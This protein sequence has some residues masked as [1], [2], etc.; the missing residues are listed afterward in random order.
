[1]SNSVAVI[2]LY[3]NEEH[4][5][6]QMTE[7]QSV[8]LGKGLKLRPVKWLVSVKLSKYQYYDSAVCCKSSNNAWADLLKTK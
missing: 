8:Y 4:K 6:K 2:M 1:M 3:D 7:K 5:L